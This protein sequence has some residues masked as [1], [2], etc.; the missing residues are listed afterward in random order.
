[1]FLNKVIKS[2]TFWVE[3]KDFVLLS[4]LYKKRKKKNIVS[5]SCL[6]ER[7]LDICIISEYVRVTI[8]I[9]N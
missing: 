6:C 5:I 1:M 9:K 8:N 4:D 3:I 7:Q 2:L